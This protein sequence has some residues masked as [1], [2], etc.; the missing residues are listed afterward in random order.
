MAVGKRWTG[1]TLETSERSGSKSLREDRI[2]IVA[3]EEVKVPAGTFVAYKFVL[4]SNLA[5][6]VRVKRTYWAQPGWGHS[7][8]V[9]REVYRPNRPPVLETTE[10]VSRT[11]GK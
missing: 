9:Q 8:K 1:R 2:R 5:N 3:Q 7:I 10:M 6:G 4:E 11:F